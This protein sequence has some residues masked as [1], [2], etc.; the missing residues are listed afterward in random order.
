[1]LNQ[2]LA[3]SDQFNFWKMLGSF[4]SDDRIQKWRETI[5]SDQNSPDKD[6]ETCHNLICLSPD[7]HAYWTKA[8]FALKPFELSDDKKRLDVEFHWLPKYNYSPTSKLNILTPP[9]SSDGRADIRLYDFPTDQR[10]CSGKKISLITDDPVTQPLP[11]PALLG[12]QWI[13]HRLAAMSGGAEIYDDFDNDDD[14]AIALWNEGD[15]YEDEWD[16]YM[17]D[18]NWNSYEEQSP[19][20]MVHQFSPPSSP[21]RQPSSHLLP[22][23]NIQSDYIPLRPAENLSIKI[24]DSSQG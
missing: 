16:L 2:S 5:F 17:E 6:V 24:I 7:A 15:P 8:Y 21:L 10:I 20:M 4:W 11:H 19:P 12:M 18:D 23:S 9:K 14:D 3:T 13:L 1:M 22:K